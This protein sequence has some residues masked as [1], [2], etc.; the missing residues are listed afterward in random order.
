MSDEK[1]I[2]KDR[3]IAY[4][5]ILGF[6][7]LLKK[8]KKYP[9][10]GIIQDCFESVYSAIEK[11]IQKNKEGYYPKENISTAILS[12]TILLSIPVSESLSS[13]T[14][15]KTLRFFLDSIS[16]IQYNLALKDIWLRGAVVQGE[17]SHL[18]ESV[19]GEGLV[20]AFLLEKEAKYPR[21]LIQPEI[22]QKL[23]P[24]SYNAGEV[25][26]RETIL[27][28][29][30]WHGY[31]PN[32]DSQFIF[33]HSNEITKFNSFTN[34]YPYFV[35][36]FSKLRKLDKNDM[37]EKEF[38]VIMKYLD[39]NLIEASPGIYQKYRWLV[40]YLT[41]TMEIE[42]NSGIDPIV[43]LVAVQSTKG[44]RKVEKLKEMKEILSKI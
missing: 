23:Y 27:N 5:D 2:F 14:R 11:S 22:F 33:S 28:D 40:D 7:E 44:D 6:R 35:D 13:G 8:A 29:L 1:W 15:I 30:N 18:N 25:V 12:D 10:K 37:L 42:I 20:S 32:Y 36:Y 16:K 43:N 21:V 31:N 4:L 9:K 26:S 19:V 34:D 24:E 3:Y 41:V 39:K 17:L 38:E